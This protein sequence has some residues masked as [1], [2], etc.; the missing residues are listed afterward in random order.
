MVV[1]HPELYSGAWETEDPTTGAIDGIHLQ[2]STVVREGAEYLQS[3]EIK[4]YR[5]QGKKLRVPGFPPTTEPI[6]PGMGSG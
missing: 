2:M 6:Q 3:L 1:S 5:A 4:V